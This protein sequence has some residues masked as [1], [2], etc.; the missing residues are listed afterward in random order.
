MYFNHGLVYLFIY[1]FNSSWKCFNDRF[2]LISL[3]YTLIITHYFQLFSVQSRL[4]STIYCLLVF[5]AV[6]AFAVRKCQEPPNP[7]T[8]SM[9]VLLFH[10]PHKPIRFLCREEL[11]P[12]AWQILHYNCNLPKCKRTWFVKGTGYD[13]PSIWAY[14]T[15]HPKHTQ[16]YFR[17]QVR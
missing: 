2:S 9:V 15:L 8:Y 17:D 7:L 11:S 1:F 3:N 4:S 5:I 14:C 13:T 16:D 12:T 6:L 10:F